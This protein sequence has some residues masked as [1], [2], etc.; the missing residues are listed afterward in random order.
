MAPLAEAGPYHAVL[1]GLG[2]LDTKGGPRTGRHG[3]VLSEN[4]LAVPGLYAAG[5]CAASCSGQGYWAAGATIGPALVF[6]HLAARHLLGASDER[7]PREAQLAERGGT[8]WL[9]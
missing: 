6:G 4:G 9:L 2:T 1:L 8:P 3:E 5:N 7:D